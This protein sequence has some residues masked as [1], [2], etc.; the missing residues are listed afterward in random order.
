MDFTKPKETI[1]RV[2]PGYF[3]DFNAFF[4]RSSEIDMSEPYVRRARGKPWVHLARWIG[5]SEDDADRRRRKIFRPRVACCQKPGG[6][7]AFVLRTR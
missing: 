6:K 1:S 3:T 5:F 7:A 2:K 4:T